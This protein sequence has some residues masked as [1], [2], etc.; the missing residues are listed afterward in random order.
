ARP[1]LRPV[2]RRAGAGGMTTTRQ[3]L[4]GLVLVAALCLL[5]WTQQQRI[6]TA[7]ARA[8]AAGERL[9]TANQRNARQAATITRLTSEL[10]IQRADQLALQ[11]TT[12][13][14]RQAHASD[15]L[16]KK[17]RE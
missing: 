9:E 12:S 13:D 4:Y 2:R 7:E 6:T 10:A 14:I 5:I 3:L 17:E 1:G 15:Q 16:K 8:D 11:Q